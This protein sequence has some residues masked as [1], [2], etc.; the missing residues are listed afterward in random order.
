MSE[1]F[2]VVYDNDLNQFQ[3]ASLE[4]WLK[5]AE[6]PR[7]KAVVLSDGRKASALSKEVYKAILDRKPL[8]DFLSVPPAPA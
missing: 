7:Y 8:S 4:E 3:S 5:V 2:T 6:N 1:K